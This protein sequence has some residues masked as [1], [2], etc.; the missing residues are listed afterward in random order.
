MNY[1]VAACTQ[2]H[3]DIFKKRI[4]PLKGSWYFADSP[5]SLSVLFDEL[6]SIEYIFFLHWREIV[7]T[8]H[9]E[10][11][12]C[13]CFHMTD[14]PYGRGGSPLQNLILAGHKETQ[15]CALQMTEVL[16]AGPVYLR[17]P[18]LLTGNAQ[19][20][21]E[22]AAGIS[23]DIIK[24]MIEANPVP[25]IQQG[26]PTHFKRRRPEQSKIPI[27]LSNTELYDFIRMLDADGYPHAYIDINGYRISFNAAEL[28][29]D[30]LEAKATISKIEEDQA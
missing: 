4:K 13:V 14:L 8:E 16:D 9:L 27:N 20:I 28:R 5:T 10:R 25:E 18:L 3:R 2:W 26:S 17:K 11:Y 1:I 29:P 6:D 12:N 15:V 30:T 22:R 19:Q 21:Y 7:P 23:W 24:E